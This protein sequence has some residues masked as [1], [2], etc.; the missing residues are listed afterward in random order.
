MGFSMLAKEYV[1][2]VPFAYHLHPEVSGRAERI[3]DEPGQVP[4][5]NR[6]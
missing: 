3:P 2:I 1:L 4:P 6:I 5:G